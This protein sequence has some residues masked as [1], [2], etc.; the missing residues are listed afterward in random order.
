MAVETVLVA[1]LGKR[2]HD[3]EVFRDEPGDVR[4]PVV[5]VA[6]AV[7]GI[8]TL[9]VFDADGD[10]LGG[11]DV[12]VA[13][14]HHVVVVVSDDTVDHLV[15]K[16]EAG[17]EEDGDGRLRDKLGGDEVGVEAVVVKPEGLHRR[18]VR[19]FPH[20]HGE[21]RDPGRI[22]GVL[23]EEAD[24]RADVVG[25]DGAVAVVVCVDETVAVGEFDAVRHG[26]GDRS[27]PPVDVGVVEVDVPG[28]NL[29]LG[30]D[31]VEIAG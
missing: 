23:V 26:D 20:A 7:P 2:G 16:E 30:D 8:D 1:G 21:G 15:R 18:R 4:V 9:L 14:R 12:E 6:D 5:V 28:A 3:G 13:E 25:G 29:R 31:A 27:R 17:G 19:V 24:L 22:E 10:V 11:E